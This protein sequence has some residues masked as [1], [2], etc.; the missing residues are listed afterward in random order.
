[1][2]LAWEP[3]STTKKGPWIL[4]EASKATVDP[5]QLASDELIADSLQTDEYSQLNEY[6]EDYYNYDDYYNYYP[7][8]D[9]HTNEEAYYEQ[10]EEDTNAENDNSFEDAHLETKVGHVEQFNSTNS[11]PVIID[12]N[13]E[14]IEDTAA[15]KI[16]TSSTCDICMDRPKDATLVCGHRYCYQCALQMRVDERV[17]A[18][19]RRCIVSVIKTYN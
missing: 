5:L 13:T 19:C 18:I 16:P 4:D 10:V 6:H 9:V 3:K 11:S 14:T 12:N 7:D 15:P 2:P 1:M 8:Q 17:C